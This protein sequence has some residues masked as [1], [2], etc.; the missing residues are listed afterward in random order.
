MSMLF[1]TPKVKVPKAE[2]PPPVPTVDDAARERTES[3]RIRRRKGSRANSYTGPLGAAIS[4]S[5]TPPKTL[6]G[7]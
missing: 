7:Q 3:D 6:T 2:A 4:Q 5:V 1:K